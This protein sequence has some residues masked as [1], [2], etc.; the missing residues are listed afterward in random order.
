MELS[1]SIL[2]YICVPF[3]F[4]SF[5]IVEK[6][7]KY[8]TSEMCVCVWLCCSPFLYWPVKKCGVRATFGELVATAATQV[9]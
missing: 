4:V 1:P 6:R 2:V 9:Y 8:I 7:K 5:D 3:R